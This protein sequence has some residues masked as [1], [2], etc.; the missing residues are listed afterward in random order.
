MLAPETNIIHLNMSLTYVM[1]N[2][3]CALRVLS[4]VC[5][6]FIKEEQ[7]LPRLQ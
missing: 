6:I 2:I 3:H 5:Y 1:F 7:Y 4:A